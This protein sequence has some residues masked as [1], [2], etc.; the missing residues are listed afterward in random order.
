MSQ[1]TD[2]E[3]VLPEAVTTGEA[4]YKEVAYHELITLLIEAIKEED[5]ISREQAQTIARQP[6]EMKRLLT[7]NDA[8]QQQLV[9]L[10]ELKQRLT[11]L[12]STVDNALRTGL[13]GG[14]NSHH[15]RCR[16]VRL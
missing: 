6:S 2:V 12:E 7:A 8:A 16:R 4:S 1:R 9:E 15:R 13:A 10:R 3:A 14:S 5:K 11:S